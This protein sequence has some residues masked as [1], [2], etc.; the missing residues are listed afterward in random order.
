MIYWNTARL[1]EAVV[2]C[3][4]AGLPVPPELLAHTSPLGWAHI[5]LTGE[6]NWPKKRRQGASADIHGAWFELELCGFLRQCCQLGGCCSEWIVRLISAAGKS[7]IRVASN[8]QFCSVLVPVE[9]CSCSFLAIGRGG[10]LVAAWTEQVRRFIMG[11]Q[12]SLRLTG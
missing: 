3:Q 1:G 6:Y 4:D 12:K 9:K 2:R 7:S 5:L 8:V 11:C 10:H